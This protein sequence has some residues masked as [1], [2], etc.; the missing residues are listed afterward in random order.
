MKFIRIP[1]DPHEVIGSFIEVW[2]AQIR[3]GRGSRGNS[4]YSVDRYL[5]QSNADFLSH[6]ATQV[7]PTMLYSISGLGAESHTLGIKNSGVTLYIAHFKVQDTKS[8]ITTL[9]PPPSGQSQ[10]VPATSGATPTTVAQSEQT[11]SNHYPLNDLS[12]VFTNSQ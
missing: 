3:G 10:T 11:G 8:V 2:G 6:P 1:I 5:N 4:S 7:T 9:T 12:H